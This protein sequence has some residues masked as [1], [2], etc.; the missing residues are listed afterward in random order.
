MDLADI[1]QAIDG[2]DTT[3]LNSFVE[4]MDI[5]TEVAKSKIEMGKAVFDPAR[6]RSKLN[7]LASRAPERYEAQTIT[8][9][10][11]LM[12]MSKAEQQRYI[13]ELRGITVSQK[14]H[15]TAAACDTPFPQTATVAC[16]GVEGAY[17]QIAAC[18]L[19]DVPDIAFFE[20]FEGVM[21]AVRDGFC[22][23]GVLPIENSTAGSVNAVYDLLAQFDFHIVR[24]LRLKIDHN[25]LVKPGTKLADVRE[26]YSHGQAI[27]QCASFIESHDLHAT[28]Y[29]NTAMS[30]EM[31]ASSGRTDVAAIASR[32]CATLYGLEVLES[33]IQDSDNNYTRFVVISREPRV[34]PG[35]NRTSLMIDR[36]STRLNSSHVK[37][38]RMPSSA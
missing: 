8:L 31:V 2:I 14:A 12:S 16:Q 3:L 11:L 5:A 18:K 35:A 33:N 38:S 23:F 20:T 30:A 13:N 21:R 25:L 19:F 4:R 24:S 27:A 29:P 32:S 10:R 1:R 26:V 28:K 7:N 17:S 22:E 6:E 36:K 34:Y 37:R 9:F 15:A